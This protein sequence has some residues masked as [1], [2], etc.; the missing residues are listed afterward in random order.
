MDVSEGS[1]AFSSSNPDLGE[2]RDEIEVKYSGEELS[3]GF[4]ARY[5]IDSLS[6]MTTE[7]VVFALQDSISPTLLTEE[8]NDDYR[9]VIMPMRI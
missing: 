8:G 2:A 4:N 6:A 9:C 1:L 7:R 5:L 3:A